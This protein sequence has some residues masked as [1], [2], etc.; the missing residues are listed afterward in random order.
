MIISVTMTTML[1]K[2]LNFDD[3]FDDDF[4]DVREN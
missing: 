4:N 1:V 3:D 2:M